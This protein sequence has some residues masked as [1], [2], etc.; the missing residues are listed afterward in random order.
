L[1]HLSFA[2][3]LIAG[4]AYVVVTLLLFY[5]LK[6][7]NRS[8]SLLAAFFSIVGVAVGA[9]NVLS[10]LAALSLV[11]GAHYLAAFEPGQ[12]QAM[13]LLS[14]KLNAQGSDIGLT[15]FGFYCL[16]VGYLI[17]RSTFLPRTVGVM[18]AIAGLCYLINSFAYFLSP[19]SAGHLVPYIFIPSVLGEAALT[20]WLL[21]FGVNVSKWEEMA[22]EP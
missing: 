2:A 1:F 6:P 19:G 20:L 12:L 7:V 14:L 18:M 4:A 8:L 17:F 5:L 21:V 22:H 10:Q 16:L 15:F 3:N 11:G 13:A 9:V